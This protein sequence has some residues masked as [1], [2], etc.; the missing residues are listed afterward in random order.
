MDG[1]GKACIGVELLLTK[2]E[3]GYFH[4]SERGV[5][6]TINLRATSDGSRNLIL[7]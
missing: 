6:Y 5:Y 7:T 1:K 4:G 3:E 2:P